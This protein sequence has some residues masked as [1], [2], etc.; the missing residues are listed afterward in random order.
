MRSSGVGGNIDLEA[1][2]PD[3]SW[4][5]KMFVIGDIANIMRGNVTRI[6]HRRP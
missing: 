4:M 2:G 1:S 6:Q 5:L 3:D